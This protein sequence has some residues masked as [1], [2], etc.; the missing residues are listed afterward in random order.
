VQLTHGVP[1]GSILGPLLF[2][3]YIND[4][5]NFLHNAPT[6]FADNACILVSDHSLESLQA[7]GH[8]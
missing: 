7:Q 3:I 2:T 4:L 5:P 6:L 8:H 1:Q